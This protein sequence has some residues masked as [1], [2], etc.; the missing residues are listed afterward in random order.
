MGRNTILILCF[1]II[2]CTPFVCRHRSQLAAQATNGYNALGYTQNGEYHAQ[3]FHYHDDKVCWLRYYGG[4][5][6]HWQKQ[7]LRDSY[8]V[9]SIEEWSEMLKEWDK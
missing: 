3:G 1:F 4:K 2:S 7:E 5:V 6:Y 8:A 9:Y